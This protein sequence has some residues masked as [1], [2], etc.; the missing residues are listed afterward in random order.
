FRTTQSDTAEP[1]LE[2]M[3]LTSSLGTQQRR[4]LRRSTRR[5]ARYQVWFRGNLR[6]RERP[7]CPARTMAAGVRAARWWARSPEILAGTCH[8]DRDGTGG[9]RGNGWSAVGM[10][11]RSCPPDDSCTRLATSRH[12]R[13]HPAR[14]LAVTAVPGQGLY[15]GGYAHAVGVG[16][17]ML[18]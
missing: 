16:A 18:G 6:S 15:V 10:Q 2:L 17:S 9:A 11:L 7:A 3:S 4:S 1:R 5:P 12:L 13:V 14:R 8:R